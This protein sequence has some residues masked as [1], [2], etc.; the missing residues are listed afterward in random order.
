[1]NYENTLEQHLSVSNQS[2]QKKIPVPMCPQQ[3]KKSPQLPMPPTPTSPYIRKQDLPG[4]P[5]HSDRQYHYK[6]HI[7]GPYSVTNNKNDHHCYQS[8]PTILQCQQTINQS[9]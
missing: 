7:S 6:Q 4:L 5:L 9:A 1:M 2:T 8:H 3:T